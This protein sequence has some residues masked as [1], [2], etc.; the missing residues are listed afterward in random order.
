MLA[1]VTDIQV[2]PQRPHIPEFTHL[3]D[4]LC[5]NR[6]SLKVLL[7]NRIGNMQGKQNRNTL[8][9]EAESLNSNLFSITDSP[10]RVNV[11]GYL[12][13]WSKLPQNVGS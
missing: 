5:L 12:L 6:Q 1:G 2:V 4:S 13:L 8:N 3:C 9:Q 7:A 10:H 11:P